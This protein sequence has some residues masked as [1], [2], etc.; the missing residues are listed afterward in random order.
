MDYKST[1]LDKSCGALFLTWFTLSV[2]DSSGVY[3]TFDDMVR[4]QP[5]DEKYHAGT[6][7]GKHDAQKFMKFTHL[8]PVLGLQL[9]QFNS[10][11]DACKINDNYEFPLELDLDRCDGKYLAPETDKNVQNRYILQSVLA[12]VGDVNAGHYYAFIRPTLSDE[13]YKFDDETMTRA[14]GR[15]AT[16]G[17]FGVNK[18]GITVASAYM[19]VYVREADKDKIMCSVGKQDIPQHL[20]DRFLEEH[21]K[22]EHKP[23]AR[24]RI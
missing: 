6:M 8:P 24:T 5:L 7:H 10:Q 20:H 12:H 9:Q 2:K 19:L 17:L 15:K 11:G 3:A 23:E 14:D 4:P 13:W 22:A 21:T 1:T 16:E 18:E